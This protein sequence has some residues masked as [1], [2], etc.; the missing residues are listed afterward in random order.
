MSGVGGILVC[1]V[2]FFLQCRNFVSSLS[3]G[4]V[5]LRCV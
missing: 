3:R 5:T 2:F 1:S 4:L